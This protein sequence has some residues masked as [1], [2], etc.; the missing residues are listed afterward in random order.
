MSNSVYDSGDVAIIRSA[1]RARYL[2][3]FDPSEVVFQARVAAVPTSDYLEIEY[4]D[5]TIGAHTDIRI[6]QMVV[7]TETSDHTA[8][9]T[10]FRDMRVADTPSATVIPVSESE[11]VLE[12]GMWI[13]VIDTYKAKRK[14]RKGALVDGRFSFE[15]LAPVI[16]G[17]PSVLFAASTTTGSFTVPNVIGRSLT[18]GTITYLWEMDV[19][20]DDGDDESQ[21]PEFTA[22]HGHQWGHLTV[23]DSNG[24][25]H[26]MHF[27]IIVQN[28]KAPTLASRVINGLRIN[29]TWQGH[30]ATL[31]AYHGVT[32]SEVMNDTRTVIVALRSYKGGTVEADP[33]AFVGYLSKEQNSTTSPNDKVVTFDVAGIW[34]R[35]LGLA[36]NQIAVRD[37]ATPAEWDDINLPTPQRVTAHILNRYSTI[38]NLCSL[39]LDD[40]TDT[41]YGGDMNVNQTSLGP[42][43]EQVTSEINAVILQDPSGELFFR[44]DLRFEDEATRD[45]ADVVWT[46]LNKD[47]IALDLGVNH[48]ENIGR[49]MIGF[50]RFLTTRSPSE[51]GKAV[52]PAV[53]LGNSSETQTRANQ[54]LR[55]DATVEE[56]LQEAAQ[57]VGD[58][59]AY[60][61]TPDQISETVRNLA[62]MTTSCHQWVEHN[63]LPA[64]NTRGRALMGRGLIASVDIGYDNATGT[65]DVQIEVFPET[66]GGRAI[67]V[68]MLV[69]NVSQVFAHYTPPQGAYSGSYPSSPTQNVPDA[70][71]KRPFNRRSM[72]GMGN[73]TPQDQGYEE[74]LLQ[75]IPGHSRFAIS[76]KNPVAVNA[77]FTSV[78]G[79]PYRITLNGSAKISDGEWEFNGDFADDDH[80]FA[81][82]PTVEYGAWT[83]GVGWETTDA[84][85]INFDRRSVNILRTLAAD[86]TYIQFVYDWTAGSTWDNPRAVAIE[87]NG[88]TLLLYDAAYTD[89]TNGTNKVAVWA[90]T[91]TT[92]DVNF[93]TNSS[94]AST[95]SYSGSALIKRFRMRGTGTNPFTGEPSSGPIYADAFWIWNLDDEGNRINILPNP[96]T[97]LK[98]NNTALTPPPNNPSSTYTVEFAG[99]GAPLPFVFFD[100][101]YTDNQNLPLWI[102]IEGEDAE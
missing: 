15:G 31:R 29:R 17:L 19:T 40:I 49:M 65:E 6:D 1:G 48:L 3:V 38:L 16:E 99:T 70:T 4:E 94:V 57:R 20:Y 89:L 47:L 5:V 92:T 95:A 7:V 30:H 72:G 66:K 27:Q 10:G 63:L 96:Y 102:D 25:T 90:G 80:D 84:F 28:P 23:T 88:S 39:N 87:A 11:F 64:L 37:V 79:A 62:W 97:G 75:P 46:L 42:A 76:F 61:N 81:P 36:F 82:E 60:E 26:T 12:V 100:A 53:T 9:I 73:P 101:S 55:A 22:P 32:L 50:R 56:M 78:L 86:L 98:I 34:E 68:A 51:G 93:L 13:T 85:K 77:G 21:N 52:A 58:L 35:A 69:P 18:G 44:R 83:N 91:L 8:W 2:V 54:L 24:P 45:D 33:V 41:W 59:L 71:T 43:V 74:G 14:P 67:V